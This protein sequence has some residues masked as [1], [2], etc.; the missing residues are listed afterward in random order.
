VQLGQK[1]IFKKYQ[2]GYQKSKVYVDF[3]SDE[4]VEKNIT[5]QTL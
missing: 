4:K 2:E 5:Q 3:K 1:N